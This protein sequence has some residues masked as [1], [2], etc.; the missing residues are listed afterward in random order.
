MTTRK[1]QVSKTINVWFKGIVGL[2]V[3]QFFKTEMFKSLNP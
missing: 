1:N 2:E 3:V